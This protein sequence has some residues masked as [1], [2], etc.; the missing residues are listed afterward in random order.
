[1]S[2]LLRVDSSIRTTGSVSRALADTAVE[3]WLSAH[4]TGTVVRRDLGTNPLPAEAWALAVG[5]EHLPQDTWSPTQHEAVAL[6]RTLADE[7][8]SAD[9]LLLAAPLYNFGVPA[10]V[11][12]WIDLLITDTRVRPGSAHLAGK[13]ALIVIARGGGYGEGAPRHGWDHSTAYLRRIFGDGFGME[14]SVAAAELTLAGVVPAMSEL[15]GL[16]EQSLAAAHSDAAMHARN[17]AE[18]LH[19]AA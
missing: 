4:P 12:A 18:R 1:M 19:A 13:S 2:T 5:A 15:I 16:G 8:I 9:T 14:I 6:A 3:A 11:K 10:S 17:L 7:L